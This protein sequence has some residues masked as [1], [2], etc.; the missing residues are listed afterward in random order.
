MKKWI[1]VAV[2]VATA[3]VGVGFAA[4]KYS[5][6]TAK[7][8]AAEKKANATLT[9][10]NIKLCSAINPNNFRDTIPMSASAQEADCQD[11]PDLIGATTYELGC[12]FSDG[13]L[14]LGPS[15][16]GAPTPNCGW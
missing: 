3:S 14:S 5:Q 11:W 16:G 4:V 15:G 10:D 2:V 13:T 7:P 9:S 12:S 6:K 8:P 1:A